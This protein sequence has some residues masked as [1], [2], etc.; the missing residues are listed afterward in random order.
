MVMEHPLPHPLGENVVSAD[1]EVL[2]VAGEA[3]V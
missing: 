2:V 1:A 3:M